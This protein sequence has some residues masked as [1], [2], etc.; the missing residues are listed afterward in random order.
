[1]SQRNAELPEN[2]RM[3]FRIG[4]NLGDIVEEEDRIYGDGVNIAARLEGLAEAGGICIS[5]TAYDQVKKKLELGYK[6]LGEH[7]VKNISEP[8]HVYRVLME[9]EAAGKVIG[10]K[11]KEKRR[12]TL[13][14]VIV[15]LIGVT[16]LAGW[17]LYLEQSKQVE[18][19]S[20]EKMAFPLP[21][22]PS[23]AVLPF[24]NVSGD[25]KD[26]YLSD[27]LTGQI[28]NSL[29]RYPRLFVIAAQSS[30]S[31][32]GKSVKVQQ[33]AEELG[34]QY[35][36][37]GG[38][39]K[40]GEKVR[41]TTQL[42]DAIS[43]HSVWSQR[44]DGEVQDIFDFQDKITIEVMNGMV[45]EL[46]EGDQVHR[47]TKSGVTNL[48]AL[49]KHYEAQGIFCRHTK[50]DY[51]KARPLF[52]EAIELDPKFVWPYLY[53]GYLHYGSAKRGWSESRE[54]S[55]Q[56]ASELAKNA[57]SIDDSHG[58]PHSLLAV[59]YELKGQYDKAVSEAEKA[60]ALNPNGMDAYLIMGGVLGVIGRWEESVLYAQKALRLNPF[61]GATPFFVLGRAYFMTGQY[62]ESVTTFKKALKVSPNFLRG[63]IFLAACYSSMGRD[64]EATAAVKEVLDRN[65]KFCIESY[66]KQL[67][68]KNEADIDR[69]LNALRNAGVPEKST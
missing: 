64:A 16:G 44:Y 10:E 4:V 17:Y 32:K 13:A 29:S 41:V 39:Q 50:E 47:W 66:T 25:T 19:A 21:E 3:L 42:I 52:E 30:L 38:V 9:P 20:M 7:S 48:K 46:V 33:V 69:L 59:I 27:G 37:E 6:Y 34:V 62:D 11:R 8:V 40:S 56:M 18:P 26:N 63:Y 54:K 55:L 57:L 35:V 5:R 65:P 53:L 61:P 15:L 45:A 22:K 49:E 43:G 2:R 36:L 12:M 24:K 23:I 51:E 28:I 31:Y 68:Y 60:I 58:G 1:M 14:A 67:T